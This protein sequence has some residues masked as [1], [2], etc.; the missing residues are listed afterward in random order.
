MDLP[1]SYLAPGSAIKFRKFFYVL[2][3]NLINVFD[4][5]LNKKS[6]CH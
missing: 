3:E 1:Q 2:S 4:K 5:A 6:A